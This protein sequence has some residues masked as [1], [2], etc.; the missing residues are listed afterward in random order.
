VQL[1]LENN[2]NTEAEDF[3]GQ[4][5]LA[6]AAIMGYED[7]IKLLLEKGAVR[8]VEDSEGRTPLSLA[9]EGGHEAAAHLLRTFPS[10][11]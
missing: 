3:F 1:L 2:A 4:T 9:V 11:S 5:P 6:V 10:T 7:I 8:E